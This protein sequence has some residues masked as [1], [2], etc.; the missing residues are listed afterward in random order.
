[1]I[2]IH[3]GSNFLKI[4]L[5]GIK[6]DEEKSKNFRRHVDELTKEYGK[7]F[8]N[9]FNHE[10]RTTIF[11]EKEEKGKLSLVVAS[12]YNSYNGDLNLT[13][14]EISNDGNHGCKGVVGKAWASEKEQSNSRLSGKDELKRL[15]NSNVEDDREKLKKELKILNM[16]ENE[17]KERLVLDDRKYLFPKMI[18][19][20]P[21]KMK[22]GKKL[23]VAVDSDVKNT[24]FKD[25]FKKDIELFSSI[26]KRIYDVNDFT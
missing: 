5:A 11:E 12:R 4:Y 10:V 21:V 13:K 25:E 9:I 7:K 15:T 26:S 1:M 18:Y 23:V 14:W 24:K 2:I 20:Y 16:S 19:A 22:N 6:H 3:Y 17:L 8:N